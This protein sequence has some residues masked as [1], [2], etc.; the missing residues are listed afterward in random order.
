VL[1]L[2]LVYTVVT[3]MRVFRRCRT[4]RRDEETKPTTIAKLNRQICGLKSIS[5]IAP[6]VGLVGTCL[7][8]LSALSGGGMARHAFIE[9]ITS[10]LA[11]AIVPCA[12]GIIVA[13]PASCAHEYG[14]PRL[15]SLLYEPPRRKPILITGRFKGLPTFAVIAAPVLAI[16][17]AFMTLGSFHNPKGFYINIAPARCNLGSDR[18]IVLHITDGDRIFLNQEEESDW[19]TLQR[20]LSEIYSSRAER[21]IYLLPDGGVSFRTVVDAIDAIQNAPQEGSL[22]SLRISV[23]LVTPATLNTRC[24]E[25]AVAPLRSHASR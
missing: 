5:C 9:W 20:R 4:T 8:L 3:F 1:S 23:Q 2:L 16:L 11:A 15:D 13:V 25:P 12:V 22:G 21:V 10:K 18:L 19:G 6:Y 7:G 24:P 17:A 14:L